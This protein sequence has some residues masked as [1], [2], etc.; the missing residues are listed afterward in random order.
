MLPEAWNVEHNNR[1]H[2]CLG[3]IHDPDLVEE[4]AVVLRNPD[5]PMLLK[6]AAVVFN[7]LFWKWYYYAPN[8]YKELKLSY[9]RKA[10]IK[11]PPDVRPERP[12]TFEAVM[13]G[14]CYFFSAWEFISRVVG[15]Y[16]LYH[17]FILPLPYLLVGSYL[18]RTDMYTNA[19]KTLFLAEVLTNIH[20][21]IAIVTNHAGDDMYRFRHGCKPY[22]GSFFLR[23]VISS[24][25]FQTGNNPCDFMHGFLNYQIEHHLWPNLSMR[26]YQ[27]AQPLVRLLC[28]KHGVPYIQQNVW[29]RVKKTVDIMVG[30]TS[31]REFPES[32]EKIFLEIDESERSLNKDSAKEEE[33]MHHHHH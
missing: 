22:S 16:F 30:N 6:Y 27:K 19:V 17:F 10:G 29:A 32:Y 7:I 5:L 20:S 24:V 9:L 33:A 21:F 3:E 1:H 15:P 13:M 4:N 12:M 26:S 18:G 8:T 14:Q 2:Y 31:M 25:D 23:Q 28:Q 11:L